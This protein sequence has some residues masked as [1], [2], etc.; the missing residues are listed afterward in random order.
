MEKCVQNNGN[1]SKGPH[2]KR[3]VVEGCC[4]CTPT[5]DAA[6]QSCPPPLPCL[7]CRHT[8]APPHGPDWDHP[9]AR[10]G[11]WA[12]TYPG[13]IQKVHASQPWLL[14]LVNLYDPWTPISSK[15]AEF[16]CCLLKKKGLNKWLYIFTKKLEYDLLIVCML[17]Q[18]L[19]L[20]GS[21]IIKCVD[22]HEQKYL[23]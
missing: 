8:D 17:L 7:L 13:L 14:S 10:C 19:K 2:E 1:F 18:S 5:A 11:L 3:T 20:S 6:L 15:T 23:N 16:I 4:H 12:I 22:S 21:R 9:Q